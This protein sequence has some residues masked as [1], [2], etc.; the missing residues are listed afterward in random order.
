MMQLGEG[1]KAQEGSGGQRTAGQVPALR[2]SWERETSRRKGPV[3]SSLLGRCLD[4]AGVVVSRPALPSGSP[5]PSVPDSLQ[6]SFLRTPA[7]PFP[8]QNTQDSP[9]LIIMV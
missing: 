3:A 8:C 2:C 6:S 7:L 5:H 9:S 4:T 1:N